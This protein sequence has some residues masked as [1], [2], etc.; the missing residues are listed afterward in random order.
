VVEN[1]EESA[2]R[3]ES[4]EKIICRYHPC[5]SF[6]KEGTPDTLCYLK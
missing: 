6:P 2:R 1:E 3:D 4:E 5:P